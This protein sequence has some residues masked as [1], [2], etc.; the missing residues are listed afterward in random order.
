MIADDA[1]RDIDRALATSCITIAVGRHVGRIATHYVPGEGAETVVQ[2]RDLRNAAVVLATGGSIAH[3]PEHATHT[4]TAAL[5]RLGRDQPAP[6]SGQVVID[7]LYIAAAAGLLASVNPTAA[8]RLL[9]GHQA[10]VERT[11]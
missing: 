2:G 11:A 5:E 8:W 9:H 10:A 4:V 3:D 1:T 7:R 6:R